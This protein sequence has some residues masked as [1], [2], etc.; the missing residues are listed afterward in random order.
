M[1]APIAE[2][3]APPAASVEEG[4]GT[5]DV[6]QAKPKLSQQLQQ[7]V[8]CSVCGLDVTWP[9]VLHSDASRAVVAHNCRKCGEVVCSLCSPAGDTLP[10]DGK[11]TFCQPIFCPKLVIICFYSLV[12]ILQQD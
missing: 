5:A 2:P 9:Y 11:S 3:V 1:E 10:G 8:P 12:F 4:K 6:A 7:W